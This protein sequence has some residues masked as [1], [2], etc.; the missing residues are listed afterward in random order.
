[1]NGAGGDLPPDS[2]PPGGLSAERLTLTLDL[3]ESKPGVVSGPLWLA[4]DGVVVESLGGTTMARLASLHMG[5][6]YMG[7]DLPRLNALTELAADPDALPHQDPE[8][9][10]TDLLAAI[11]GVQTRVELGD[12][13]VHG[14]DGAGQLQ[15]HS[16]A[17]DTGFMPSE[18][19]PLLHDLRGRFQA[20][21]W[22]FH[23][24]DSAI[25]V[26]SF[27]VDLRL[28]RVAPVAL[29]RLGML[30]MLSDDIAAAE[31][32]G[33]SREILGGVGLG[34]SV[35][36]VA[37]LMTPAPGVETAPFG[38]ERLEF[39]FGLSDLDSRTPG[40]SLSYRHRGLSGDATGM[41][42][43]PEELF[44][45]E[46]AVDL[47]AS[48]LPVGTLADEAL[49][50]GEMGARPESIFLALLENAT[51]LDINEIVIDLPI[52]GLRFTGHAHAEQGGA[53]EPGM[54]S[55]AAEM[56]IRGLD[57][58]V[59]YALAFSGSEAARQQIIGI[60]TILKLASEK[61]STE[62]GEVLH[63]FRVEGDSQGRLMV[64]DNDLG[65]LL[66]GGAP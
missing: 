18:S 51:R 58:V 43:I 25:E 44:P 16:A 63:G 56:E 32:I 46:V 41:H 39:G 15:L 10:L 29:L 7:L 2:E 12:L 13:A 33:F 22:R 1:M 30:S 48:S 52:A 55:G 5:A 36:G 57:T 42:P 53:P 60:A 31:L 61:R 11:G 23:D 14:P 45:R 47:A 54:L 24:D 49:A 8:V 26:D 3:D 6:D 66:M 65:T 38:L 27:G 64:N 37:G 50:S 17:L 19:D 20:S 40:L 59:E 4:L 28:D 34:L 9:L 35:G 21:G 62:D